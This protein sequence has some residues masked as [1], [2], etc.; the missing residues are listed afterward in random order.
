MKKGSIFMKNRQKQQFLYIS[1]I[2]DNA[3]PHNLV[4]KIWKSDEKQ[5]LGIFFSK[6]SGFAKNHHKSDQ[7]LFICKWE[8]F[9]KKIPESSFFIRFP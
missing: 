7:K 6:I 9:T 2:E 1:I 4:K 3:L 5:A 8:K